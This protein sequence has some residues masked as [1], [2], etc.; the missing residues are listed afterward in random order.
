MNTTIVKHTG[1]RSVTLWA[2]L[3]LCL[4]VPA[5]FRAPD[6]S[7]IPCVGLSNCPIGYHCAKNQGANQGICPQG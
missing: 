4:S 2:A 5:C 7:K 1:C 3:L 6:T